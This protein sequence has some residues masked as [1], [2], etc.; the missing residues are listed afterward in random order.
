MPILVVFNDLL[1]LASNHCKISLVEDLI[2]RPE[3][4]REQRID[5][6]EL[7]GASL[8]LT[9]TMP[10]EEAAFQYIKRG[11]EERFQNT[12]DPILKQSLQPVKVYQNKMESQTFEEL[13]LI[14]L[15]DTYAQEL[16]C[17]LIM[18]R[19]LGENNIELLEAIRSVTSSC[20]ESRYD[21]LVGLCRYAMKIAQCYNQ[22]VGLDLDHLLFL[23]CA[24][25]EESKNLPSQTDV[26]EVLDQVITAFVKEKEKTTVESGKELQLLQFLTKDELCGN[27]KNASVSCILQKLCALN[28][29]DEEGNTLLHI[30]AAS[31]DPFRGHGWFS[32]PNPL[33]GFPC[34]KTVQLLLDA[35]FNVN[36][37]NNNGD[38]PLHR[39]AMFN[40]YLWTQ[41]HRITK[42]LEVLLLGGAH[43]DYTNK[44][45][46]TAMDKSTNVRAKSFLS[47]RY[48]KTLCL[49][50]VS[51]RAVKKY[52]LPYF[53]EVPKSV[54]KFIS[55]H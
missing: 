12:S 31:R 2:K 48:N 8:C 46:L 29:C 44:D 7:L 36:A 34:I 43:L 49:K 5:A 35:G 53:G 21:L 54:E 23:Y 37:L 39:A 24:A 42:M 52:G 27:N 30:A 33:L 6:L 17:L 50:C 14:E 3:C 38:T 26:L 45:G 47:Y 16:E 20:D 18:E 4:S 55:M 51:A 11:M 15:S 9:G 19:I 13:A 41:Y 40:P 25:F 1:L 32:V 10:E 22:T 28:P